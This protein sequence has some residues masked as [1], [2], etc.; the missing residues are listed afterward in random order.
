MRLLLLSFLVV[1]CGSVTEPAGCPTPLE[2]FACVAADTTGALTI[3]VRGCVS[4]GEMPVV[5][6]ICLRGP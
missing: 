6:A 2:V 5:Q 3:D 4:A 1:A